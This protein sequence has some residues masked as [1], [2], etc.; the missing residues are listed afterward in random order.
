[1]K[2]LDV[3]A[4]EGTRLPI[5]IAG[6]YRN[7]AGTPVPGHDP[8]TGAPWTEIPDCTAGEVGTARSAM[9]DPAWR[10]LSQSTR[11]ASL[12]RFADIVEANTG[13]LARIETRDNGRILR[14]MRALMR[15]L[16][17]ALRQCA[18]MADRVEGSTIPLGKPD[19][20]TLTPREPIAVIAV[21][22]RWNS[23]LQMMMR[24]L[25]P[26]LAPC[27]AAGNAVGVK[28]SELASAAT[29]GLAELMGEAVFRRLCTRIES[30]AP[31]RDVV[32]VTGLFLFASEAL[33]ETLRTE[34][35]DPSAL[36]P[37]HVHDKGIGATVWSCNIAFNTEV[38][39]GAKPQAWADVFDTRTF[40]G[41]RAL[42]DR[43]HPMMGNALLA[44]RVARR[45]C[46]R[47]TSPVPSRSPIPSRRT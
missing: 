2:K 4:I 22:I 7:S 5:D 11:G 1:M 19:M 20:P 31:V 24:A 47:S 35:A 41:K 17:V 36:D 27:L 12:L 3:E 29:I 16:P 21:S 34:I 26:C 44:D 30:G 13:R 33:F 8:A 45:I 43:A 38:T 10:N 15:S 40:P 46:A 14:E 18:G 42:R 25:A 23:P 6:A 39:G 37:A 32:D 9:D 28:P